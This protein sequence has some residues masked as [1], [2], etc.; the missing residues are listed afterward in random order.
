MVTSRSSG[1]SYLNRVKL[2]NGCLALAHTNLFIPSTLSGSAYSLDTGELDMD[3]VR[4]NLELA[5]SVYIDWVDKCPCGETVIHLFKGACSESLQKERE[6][7][8][9]FLKGTKKEEL[10]RNEPQLYEY[11]TTVWDTKRRHEVAGLPSQYIYLL[12]CCFESNCLHPLCQSGREGIAMEWFPG[13]PTI[14]QIPMPVPD[15]NHPWGKNSRE[16]C[17]GFC[18]GH[19]LNPEDALRSGIAPM[20]QPPLAILKDFYQSLEKIQKIS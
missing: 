10:R 19:F 18:S 17:D 5:T 14:T 1:S 20:V 12:V 11:F 16:K 3:H 6:H 2:Q 15:P 4:N 13:G 9:V 7:L 8:L